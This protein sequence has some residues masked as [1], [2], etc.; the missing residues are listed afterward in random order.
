MSGFAV[1]KLQARN[2]QRNHTAFLRGH[3]GIKPEQK[4]LAAEAN[5]L[6]ALQPKTQIAKQPKD[7]TSMQALPERTWSEAFFD[8]AAKGSP[9]FWALR[10]LIGHRETLAEEQSFAENVHQSAAHFAQQTAEALPMAE[11]VAVWLVNK[12]L[13]SKHQ[14]NGR[15]LHAAMP[16]VW[17][18]LQGKT[19]STFKKEDYQEFEKPFGIGRDASNTANAANLA[20]AAYGLV[21]G[22]LFGLQAVK[23]GLKTGAL[24]DAAAAV[25]IGLRNPG[26]MLGLSPRALAVRQAN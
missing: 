10:K 9:A 17:A 8:I 13:G 20:F 24:G 18:F 15:P 3:S 16:H 11:S 2:A 26:R 22:G 14:I 19:I 25:E 4:R 23:S 21:K 12:S 1:T 7:T 6:V 5:K